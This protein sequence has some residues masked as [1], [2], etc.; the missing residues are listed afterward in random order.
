MIIYLVIKTPMFPNCWFGGP[1]FNGQISDNS[2]CYYFETKELA[3]SYCDRMN[4]SH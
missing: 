3:Q 4:A 2:P 1:T